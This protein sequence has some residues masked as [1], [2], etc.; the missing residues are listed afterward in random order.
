M[1]I[2]KEHSY[3]SVYMVPKKCIVKSRSEC[4]I[5]VRLGDRIFR[6]PIIPADMPSVVNFETC[7]AF[8]ECDMFY[9]MHRFGLSNED[10]SL[11][12]K[13]MNEKYGWSSISIGIKETDEELIKF[14]LYEGNIPTYINIDIAHAYSNEC[15]KMIEFI[16]A[17]FYTSPFIIAGNV[18]TVEAVNYLYDAGAEAVRIFIA[19][20]S[21]CSTKNATG[22]YRASIEFIN[23]CFLRSD[24]P[25]IA[26]GGVTEPGDVA[27]AIGAGAHMV[28]AGGV[29]AGH[30]ESPGN[31]IITNGVRK[32]CYYGNAS[33]N[34]KGI[35]KHI[36]GKDYLIDPRGPIINT[37]K[38]YEEGLKSAISYNGDNSLYDFRGAAD[39][40]E[41]I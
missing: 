6:N 14:L 32:Y 13:N 12:V 7:K 31:I 28:M 38:S 10:V 35:K 21:G 19:P 40:V 24:C 26:D 36:E 3:K 16:K 23:E 22:F 15:V 18:A 30:D 5:S 29:L 2:N 11:F 39:F 1:I 9:V 25:I 20:G 17:A 4:D 27:K 41:T 34:N 33:F 8:A 37:I